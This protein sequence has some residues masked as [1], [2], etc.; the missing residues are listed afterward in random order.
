M[1][2]MCLI[3]NH[4]RCFFL[5]LKKME[6][7]V[8]FDEFYKKSMKDGKNF[9]CLADNFKEFPQGTSGESF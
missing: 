2:T 5:F 9:S 4:H 8:L 1:L 7:K 3:K 6:F